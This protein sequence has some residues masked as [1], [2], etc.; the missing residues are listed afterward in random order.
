MGTNYD[1][2]SRDSRR[3]L[4][5]EI[6]TLRRR[7]EEA[8]V[9]LDAISSGRI[10]ALVVAHPVEERQVLVLEDARRGD[11]LPIDR[12]RQGAI[13]LSA[14]G[15]VIY[16]NAAFAALVGC[17]AQRLLGRPIRELVSSRDYGLVAALLS[18]RNVGPLAALSFARADGTALRVHVA[19]IPLVDGTGM[20]LVVTAP[21]H[22]AEDDAA[23]TVRA[24]RRGEIDAVVVADQD[25]DDPKV[26]LLGAAGRRYRLLVEHMRD[27]AV[28]LSP[29]GVV[30]YANPS[31]AAMI[32]V[33]EAFSDG[34]RGAASQAEVTINRSNGGS[35]RAS[36]TPLPAADAYGVSLIVS[37]LTNRL[38]L[39]EAEQTLRAIGSGEVDAFVV[40]RDQIDEVQT[41][42]GAH[43]P[44]RVMVERMQQGAVT[45][46][47]R[48]DILYTNQPF[49]AMLGQPIA[50]LIGTPL[51]ELVAPDD[52]ALLAAL[53]DAKHGSTTQG[54]LALLHRDGG[55]ISTLVAV[56]LLPEEGGVC[57]IVTDLTKQKAYEAMVAAQA[58]ERSILEQAVDAIVLCD[59]DGRVIRASRAALELASQNPLLL[60]F[61]ESFALESDDG[62][63]DL[64][65]ALRGGPIR[66]AEYT[67]RRP[68]AQAA[69]V[70]LSAGPITD[71]DGNTRGCVVTMTD[72]S[73]RRAAED[74][75][76]ESDR[77]KDEFL[78]ILAHELRNPL[79]PIRT[80]VEILRTADLRAHRNASYAVEIIGRQSSNLIRLVDDLLDINRINQGKIVLQLALIDMRAVLEQAIETCRPLISSRNHAL[81]ASVP[82]EPVPVR[83]DMVRLAQVVVNLL[84]NAANYTPQ[85]GRIELTLRA[86]TEP[87]EAVVS[88]V[89]NGI[90]I[91]SE[92]VAR[93]FEPYQQASQQKDRATGGLGLGLTVCKRLMEMHG[94]TV[95]A[96][97]DGPGRGARFVVRL[98]L[99][100]STQARPADSA[101]ALQRTNP[102]R[103]LVVD[104]NRDAAE[105]LA[106]LM[107]M[108]GHE[109]RT[110][111]NGAAAVANA[112][113]FRPHVVLLDIGMPGMNGY[114]V[115]QRLRELP[116]ADSMYL[117][118][119]TGYGSEEDRSRSAESGFD[120]HLVKPLD[121][122]ALEALLAARP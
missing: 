75:L 85:G 101:A 82:S 22:D 60:P 49:A 76:R 57:L 109:V 54:E 121:F 21:H 17:D 63:P 96:Q 19:C 81:E 115:A 29:D 69:T 83:G 50:T 11:R 28:T 3:L 33:L 77:H 35:F 89:D 72:I 4:E 84:T 62:P 52:R 122:A 59:G 55:R 9:T 47:D 32:G 67:L 2:P 90:G 104:D 110:L 43:R 98:A 48:G 53:L 13:T 40:A 105:S 70:L 14:A 88:V 114:E 36:L 51:A 119:M 1:E 31:F 118:A 27:G 71:A 106:K 97:S 20:C 120:E 25:E 103:V 18:D 45:L 108:S 99:A 68:G 92:M 16:V 6:D 37:D 64:K 87:A 23:A 44:Y 91:A 100:D 102:L 73:E 117:I 74:R 12:L 34:R 78:A 42:T 116:E 38:R 112:A 26:L 15:E 5:A 7:L 94:G 39:D 24:L 93:I 30:L 61:A 111:S 65:A 66:G 8:E 107:Q 80:A 86:S 56:A 95:H 113:S 46:S 79:A 41:L 58:L 10:D